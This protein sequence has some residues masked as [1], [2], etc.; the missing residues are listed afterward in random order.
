VYDDDE[1]QYT[2]QGVPQP[3]GGTALPPSVLYVYLETQRINLLTGAIAF[4]PAGFLGGWADLQFR[5]PSTDPTSAALLNNQ[6]YVGVEHTSPGAFVSVGYAAAN[7]N[8]QFN[9]IPT[10]PNGGPFAEPGNTP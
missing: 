4:N 7:L 9:C 3:S 6:A 1:R 5:G 8:N 2:K 10:Y